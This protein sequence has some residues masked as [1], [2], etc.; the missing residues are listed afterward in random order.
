MKTGAGICTLHAGNDTELV[1]YAS[2]DRLLG[3][4]CRFH[5]EMKNRP[6]THTGNEDQLLIEEHWRRVK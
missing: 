2:L 5:C 6:W 3:K 4:S 1:D